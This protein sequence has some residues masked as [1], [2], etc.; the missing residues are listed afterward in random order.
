MK[1]RWGSGNLIDQCNS[2]MDK[3][4]SLLAAKCNTVD[5]LVT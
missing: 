5:V 3:I 1:A 2:V 4:S